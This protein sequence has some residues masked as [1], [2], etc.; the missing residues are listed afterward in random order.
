LYHGLHR[1][2]SVEMADADFGYVGSGKGEN[3]AFTK[4]KVVKRSVPSKER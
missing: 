1:E 3:N 4:A 2:W